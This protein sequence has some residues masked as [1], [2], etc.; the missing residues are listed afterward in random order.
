MLV[1]AAGLL[2]AGCSGEARAPVAPPG[3]DAGESVTVVSSC[4]LAQSPAS[5]AV[6]LRTDIAYE[7]ADGQTE[8]LDIALPAAGGRHPLVV[9]IHGG[10][11]TS[12][13][14]GDLRAEILLLAQLGYV[15]ASLDYRLADAPR[16]VFPAAVK[17]VRCA[18]RWL[19]SRADEYGIDPA[20]VAAVGVSAGGHLASMLG[21]AAAA[22]GLDEPACSATQPPVD[23]SAVVSY[24]G[25]QDLR[26]SGP[27]TVEQAVLV[28]NFLGVFPGNAPAL[29]ASASPIT[30]VGASAAPFL[31]VHGTADPLVPVD[32]SRRMKTALRQA[33]VKATLLELPSVGHDFVSIGSPSA[34]QVGCTILAFLD[35]W[36]RGA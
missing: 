31:L 24:A 15:A 36:L 17:D 12:G 34:P 13:S 29:A 3:S 21:V 19:R 18:V 2:A 8:R 4:A 35:R 25:P 6:T 22:G 14:K 33:G 32:Q 16:N 7:T 1:T 23:V 5:T 9:L 10:A 26:V 30:Y 11:W 28:T 20:R 27:Y